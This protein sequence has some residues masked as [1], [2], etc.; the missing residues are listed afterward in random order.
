MIRRKL[1]ERKD[2]KV[3]PLIGTLLLAISVLLLLVT[4]PIGFVYGLLYTLFKSGLRGVGEYFLKIAVSIDQL[5]NVTMQHLLNTLWI[6]KGGYKFGNRDETISSA[7]GRNKRLGTLTA[8]GKLIDRLLDLI[9]PNHSLNSID[10]YIEP[11]ED[12][13]DEL[14]WIHT[15]DRSL[16][17]LRDTGVRYKIPG[18]EKSEI[19][20]DGETLYKM[21][22]DKLG[23]ELDIAGLRMEEVFLA[24][25]N[26]ANSYIRKTCYRAKFS[27]SLPLTS[28]V[29]EISWLGYADRD[30]VSQ[31]DRMIFEYLYQKGELA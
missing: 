27:G 1:P 4:T 19:D 8:F 30:A 17:C 24:E 10:Y 11:S 14:A 12:I 22:L 16:L 2:K 6:R 25:S 20:S 21:V 13:L 9:D 3:H 23:V 31:V 15:R 18:A 26:L 29:Q 5:G 28:H 7:I